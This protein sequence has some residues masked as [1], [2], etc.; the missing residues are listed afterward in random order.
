MKLKTLMMALA[1]FGTAA[2]QIASA[3]S[4]PAQAA[5]AGD[6]AERRAL[7]RQLMDI[8]NFR[9][10]MSAVFDNIKMPALSGSSPEAQADSEQ[11]MA[12]MKVAFVAVAPDMEAVAVDVYSDIFTVQELKDAV[13]FYSSPS[14]RA[15]MTKLPLMA[16]KMMPMMPRFMPKW[17]DAMEADYCKHRKCE[18]FHHA[19]FAKM[20][21][22]YAGMK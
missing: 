11:L 18:D 15:V 16:Q 6:L 3:Q 7:A 8:L 19:M 17:V 22:A 2:P 1:L 5:S 10:M 20:R 12:S 14:G 13:T 9:Q 4:A 21:E